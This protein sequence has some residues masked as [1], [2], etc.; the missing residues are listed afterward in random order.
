MSE[1]YNL[2]SNIVKKELGN[3]NSIQV[4][5]CRVIDVL[6]NGTVQVELV[7]TKARYIVA[8]CS[9]STV[10]IGE[11]VQLYYRGI[12][13]NYTA[14]IGASFYKSGTI[15][16]FVTM[17]SKVGLVGSDFSL[18]SS[19]RI[20]S[21]SD[22]NIEITYNA[23]ILGTDNGDIEFVIRI[24]G[25]EHSYK[26]TVSMVVASKVPVCFS[27]PYDVK[28]GNH[29]VEIFARGLSNI[30]C[31]YGFISGQVDKGEIVFGDVSATDFIFID[32]TDTVDIVFYTGDTLVVQIP[33][34]RDGKPVKTICASTFN[35]SNVEA[36]YIPDGVTAIE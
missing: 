6:S 11:T 28:K 17:D 8:N 34:A 23:T 32:N 29:V 21:L 18:V 9:G 15:R 26:P 27:I 4:I 10:S 14:Y 25:I 31:A 24:D 3:F 19:I 16:N 5:P 12:I 1:L 30:E 36:V 13:S 2:I 35:V 20:K 33:N 22:T 7:S